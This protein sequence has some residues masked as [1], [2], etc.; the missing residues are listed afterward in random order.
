M[1]LRKAIAWR[2]PGARV[3]VRGGVLERWEGPMAEPSAGELAQAL[4]DY[5][6]NQSTIEAEGRAMKQRDLDIP[7]VRALLDHLPAV[8]T[9]INAGTFD[10]GEAE[11][12]IFQTIRVYRRGL[13][14]E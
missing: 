14:Q 12:R 5:A 4:T 13:K 2:W 10:A 3:V 1:S 7:L 6:A 8:V 11:N 9:A